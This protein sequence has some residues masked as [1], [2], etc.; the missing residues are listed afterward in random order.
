MKFRLEE[1]CSVIR[2][3]SSL[4]DCSSVAS[5]AVPIGMVQ[6]LKRVRKNRFL[7]AVFFLGS[8]IIL[9]KTDNVFLLYGLFLSRKRLDF[10]A[11][12]DETL[13]VSRSAEVLDQ[14]DSFSEAN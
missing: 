5:T 4:G 2:A 14:M 12:L 7:L 3:R 13:I 6:K 10:A 11:G 1:F 8:I 9:L